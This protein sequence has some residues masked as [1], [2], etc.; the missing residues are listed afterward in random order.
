[1]RLNTFARSFILLSFIT[2]TSTSWA[3]GSWPPVTGARNG[4]LG[5]AG[6][7]YATDPT[8]LALN[9]ALGVILGEQ[10][11]VTPALAFFDYHVNGTSSELGI[12]KLGSITR[13]LPGILLGYNHYFTDKITGG[14][15]VTGFAASTQ[16]HQSPLIPNS[17]APN[18]SLGGAAIFSFPI[19]FSINHSFSIGI[20][21][22][23]GYLGLITDASPQSPW[24]PYANALGIG[25]RFGARYDINHK[26]SIGGSVTTPTRFAQLSQYS[27]I[28][29]YHFQLPTVLLVGTVFHA[30]PK[31][32]ILFD[33]EEILWASTSSSGRPANIGGA[34]W[35]NA[36]DF[37]VGIQQ[38]INEKLTLRGGYQ[39]SQEVI[40][41]SNIYPN[42]VFNTPD[43]L[44]RDLITGGIG[45]Q[46]SRF[47]SFDLAVTYG[48]NVTLKDNG[49]GPLGPIAAGYSI[50]GSY[51]DVLLGLNW[52]FD[53]T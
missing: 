6:V 36:Y 46:S 8:G 17:I 40:P 25:A 22:R 9:P 14:V 28:L 38:Q 12:P 4:A 43:N 13:D 29:K 19:A 27:D 52:M 42:N 33:F 34:A 23:I 30:T 48:L 3:N 31:T 41:T 10:L 7:A 16:F 24:E 5:G 2:I 1:M 18:K 39:F 47:F 49:Q 21:P 51:A 53:A 32:D 44:T 37:K 35:M 45:Y 20:S 50:N 15:T 11:T 26:V